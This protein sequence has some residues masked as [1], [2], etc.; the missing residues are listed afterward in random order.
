MPIFISHAPSDKHF[1]DNLA[2]QLA[3]HNVNVWIDP[4]QFANGDSLRNKIQEQIHGTSALLVVMSKETDEAEWCRNDLSPELIRE[5]EEK[6]IVVMPVII[7]DCVIPEWARGRVFADL[8]TNSDDGLCTIIEEVARVTNPMQ[9][10][11]IQHRYNQD[12]AIEWRVVDGK[13]IA[14]FTFVLMHHTLSFSCIITI[15]VI[16]N[17]VA[18][19]LYETNKADN[20]V[21]VAKLHVAKALNDYFEAMPDVVPTLSDANELFF[22]TSLSRP[23]SGEDYSV[24]VSIRTV[25][26]DPG[27]DVPVDL[28][29]VVART[30]K[31][32]SEVL[33]RP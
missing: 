1:A 26:N 25:G 5:L 16:G 23:S 7:D 24:T 33:H 2:V 13:L 15:H 9:A 30:Y 21:G 4:W 17:Q 11:V 27:R 19:E 14:I 28:K 10:R 22:Q 29:G 20:G 31:H 32:M 18:T 12:W 3:H 8:R 6:N